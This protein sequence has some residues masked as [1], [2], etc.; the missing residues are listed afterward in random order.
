MK[1][2]TI[3]FL[4]FISLLVIVSISS[5]N[6]QSSNTDATMTLNSFEKG[7]S[8]GGPSECDGHYHSDDTLIVALSTRWYNG[9][10]R[11]FKN[12]NINYSGRTVQAMVV[13]ECD[14]TRGCKDNIVDASKA[15]WKALAVPKSEWGETSVTWS[16]A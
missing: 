12:I 9:G 1:Q 3:V 10:Q 5:T 6:A 8:G 7:G 11:C 13:D 4:I 14:S 15:V 2:F 16:D